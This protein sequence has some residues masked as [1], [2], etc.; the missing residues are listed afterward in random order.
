MSLF[1]LNFLVAQYCICHF[2]DVGVSS[3]KTE[4]RERLLPMMLST[5][6]SNVT[7]ACSCCAAHDP[8]NNPFLPSHIHCEFEKLEIS[9]FSMFY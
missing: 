8:H 2:L 7:S 1:F 3:Y 6:C 4:T 9:A 5:P